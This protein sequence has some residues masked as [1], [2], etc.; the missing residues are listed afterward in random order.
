MNVVFCAFALV[1][2]RLLLFSIV[3]VV[4][5]TGAL[6]QMEIKRDMDLKN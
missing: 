1:L 2:A 3:Y 5:V 4:Y 6:K